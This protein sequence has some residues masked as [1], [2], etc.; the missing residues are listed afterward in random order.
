METDPNLNQDC[1]AELASVAVTEL[2]ASITFITT[3]DRRFVVQ[4]PRVMLENL[5]LQITGCL[6]AL[7][8][9]LPRLRPSQQG[10]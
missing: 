4:M 1:E 6:A 2:T 8:S 7:P 3:A 5:A 10:R 9:I